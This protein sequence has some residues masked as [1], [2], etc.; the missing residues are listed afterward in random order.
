MAGRSSQK[1]KLSD[2]FEME[3]RKRLFSVDIH[4]LFSYILTNLFVVAGGKAK[5]D[6]K[7]S[8]KTIPP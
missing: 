1:I 4:N 6:H 8:S 2:L 3:K 5:T 7:L